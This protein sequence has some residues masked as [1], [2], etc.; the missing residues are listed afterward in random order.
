MRTRGAAGGATLHALSPDARRAAPPPPSAGPWGA[1]GGAGWPELGGRAAEAMTVAARRRRGR[2]ARSAGEAGG[3]TG[4][5]ERDEDAERAGERERRARAGAPGD[6]LR[7]RLDPSGGG[8]R[9][10]AGLSRPRPRSSAVDPRRP[11]GTGVRAPARARRPG[12]PSAESLSSPGSGGGRGRVSLSER[13]WPTATQ[14]PAAGGMTAGGAES[15]RVTL[16]V[17]LNPGSAPPSPPARP[18]PPSGE[19]FA[20]TGR[21][22]PSAAEKASDLGAPRR[23]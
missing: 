16:A 8:T 17:D 10:R 6:G 13:P 3:R 14:A 20:P 18:A 22:L 1:D 4:E 23:A 12:E 11:E 7:E 15:K 2:G 19:L 21:S 9:R 5:T